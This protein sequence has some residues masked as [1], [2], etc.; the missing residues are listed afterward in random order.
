MPEL[1]EVETV[2]RGLAP[3]IEGAQIARADVPPSVAGAA[4]SL[5]VSGHRGVPM[6]AMIAAEAELLAEAARYRCVVTHVLSPSE[7]A[8][9]LSAYAETGRR[10]ID[11][12]RFLKIA[13]DL[14]APAAPAIQEA[15]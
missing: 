9:A 10:G 1:P 7:A 4:Q 13:I 12:R 8:Q 11:G 5:H 15:E 3:A 6:A 14:R 2:R